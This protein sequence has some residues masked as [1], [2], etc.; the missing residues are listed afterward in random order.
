MNLRRGALAVVAVLLVVAGTPV[1]SASAAST[2]KRAAVPRVIIDT[3]LS[4]WWD[5]ATVLGI[6]NV[7][8]ERGDV[9][10][11]GIVSDVPNHVAVAAIDAIDTA[12]GHGRIPI[13]DV[14]GS[15]AD[16]FAHGYTD[17]VVAKLPHSIADSDDT[18]DAVALYRKLLRTSRITA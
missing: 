16:T 4:R 1:A 13:G 9:R 15:A 7:L 17:D 10:V 18:P 14:A 8:H 12:Y 6:A 11:L 2:A 5:D 3:D